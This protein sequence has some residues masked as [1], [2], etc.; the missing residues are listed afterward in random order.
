MATPAKYELILKFRE[1][2]ELTRDP[3][4]QAVTFYLEADGLEFT[5]TMKA[6]GFKKLEQAQAQYPEW[7]AVLAGTMGERTAKGFVLVNVNLQVFERKV[8]EPAA[9]LESSA[10]ESA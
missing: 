5:V 2:P 10:P 3:Q 6:K 9:P 4:T 7:S 8:R 1:Y